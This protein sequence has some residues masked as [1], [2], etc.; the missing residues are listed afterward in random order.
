[1]VS[2]PTVS[3]S[4]VSVLRV[5]L[6]PVVLPPRRKPASTL[7]PPTGRDKWFLPD[8]TVK[9]ASGRSQALGVATLGEPSRA[10]G[11]SF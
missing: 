11:V 1:M 7:P 5:T 10:T 6:V 8:A 4:P 2:N 9:L 3:H